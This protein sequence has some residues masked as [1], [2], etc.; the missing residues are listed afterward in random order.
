MIACLTLFRRPLH[1]LIYI[2][3]RSE[4]IALKEALK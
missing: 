1:Q 3:I 2:T 4:G